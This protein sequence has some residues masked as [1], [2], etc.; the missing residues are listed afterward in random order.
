MLMVQGVSQVLHHY[1]ELKR[2]GYEPGG[3]VIEA[4]S[5][6]GAEV[7]ECMSAW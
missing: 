6:S 4:K 3:E 5:P 1:S 2:I 7:G